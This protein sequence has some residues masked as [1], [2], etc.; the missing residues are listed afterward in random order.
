MT[1]LYT[2]TELRYNLGRKKMDAKY[3]EKKLIA[4]K[5]ILFSRSSKRGK[6]F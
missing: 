5:Y 2:C 3:L 6:L 4:T 1:H